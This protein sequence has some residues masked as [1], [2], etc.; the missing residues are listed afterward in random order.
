VGCQPRASPA[1]CAVVS[2]R[3][4]GPHTQDLS[5]GNAG[6]L[7]WA[8]RLQRPWLRTLRSGPIAKPRSGKPGSPMDRHSAAKSQRT[9][10]AQLPNRPWNES[11]RT[12][13]PKKMSRKRPLPPA[14]PS[15]SIKNATSKHQALLT[16]SEPRAARR[17][18]RPQPSGPAR[19]AS[20]S[21]SPQHAAM[22]RSRRGWWSRSSAPE[23]TTRAGAQRPSAAPSPPSSW[24]SRL[25][26]RVFF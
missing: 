23:F 25:S 19:G 20:R 26:R 24:W 5:S 12:P 10:G 22:G 14:E 1:W 2:S 17:R 15:R 18:P 6:P 21:I 4:L 13:C 7:L 8:G 9:A 3:V 16:S 11:S